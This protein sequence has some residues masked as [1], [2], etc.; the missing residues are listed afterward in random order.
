MHL[1][2]STAK[3]LPIVEEDGDEALGWLGDPLI[4]PD[5]G[6]IEGF[7]IRTPEF[8]GEGE[9]FCTMA[10]ILR[11]GTRV[12]VSHAHVF[13]DPTDIIR[14]RTLLSDPRTLLWQKIRTER[15]AT[16]GRCK[17]IQFDTESAKITWLFP[18]RFFRFGTAIPATEIIEVRP[19]AIIVRDP[20]ATLPVEAEKEKVS[21]LEVLQEIA[22]PTMP[23][24]SRTAHRH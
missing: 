8:M 23:T 1:R 2:F 5:R 19:E 9:A 24:P 17:D 7:F 6:I 11:W 16:I 10:D 20:Q 18:K 12:T 14:L 13:T 21:P 4:D 15:G 3:G 22:E